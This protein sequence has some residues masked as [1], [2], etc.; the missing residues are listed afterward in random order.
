MSSKSRMIKVR[1]TARIDTKRVQ[2]AVQRGKVQSLKSAGALVYKIARNSIAYRKS[3]DLHAKPGKPPFTHN[4][5]LK[6]SIRFQAEV[7]SVFIGPTRSVFGLLGQLHEFGGRARRTQKEKQYRPNN[8]NI[9]PGG[10]GPVRVSGNKV[11][12]GKLHTPKQVFR[13]KIL[14]FQALVALGVDRDSARK[15]QTRIG[16][17]EK[18]DRTYPERPFMGPALVAARPQLPDQW[19]DSIREY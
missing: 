1:V 4:R 13:A 14:S 18:N 8:W 15:I 2:R 12:F 10:H 3:K 9:K 6:R 11:E 19:K 7:S 5:A 16:A 17:A